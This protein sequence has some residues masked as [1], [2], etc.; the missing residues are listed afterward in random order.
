MPSICNDYLVRITRIKDYE[1]VETVE[2]KQFETSSEDEIR[3]TSRLNGEWYAIRIP[4]QQA[5]QVAN[6]LRT[7]KKGK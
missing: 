1:E 7:M 6:V 5:V 2:L 4:M 3:I